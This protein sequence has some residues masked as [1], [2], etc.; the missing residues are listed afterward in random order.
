MKITINDTVYEAKPS[1][2]LRSFLV[3]AG[4][5]TEGVAIALSECVVPRSEWETVMLEDGMAFIMI[6]AVSGG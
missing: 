6:Q 3:E 5:P 4:L 1:S 2:S